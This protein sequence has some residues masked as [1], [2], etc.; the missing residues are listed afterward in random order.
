MRLKDTEGELVFV[1]DPG[2]IP[3]THMVTHSCHNSSSAVFIFFLHLQV[4]G[5]RI[6]YNMWAEHSCTYNK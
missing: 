3:N 4:P 5:L 1:E 6:V 2:L